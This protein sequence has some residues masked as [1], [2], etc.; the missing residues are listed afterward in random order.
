V[1]TLDGVPASS[2]PLWRAQSPYPL[3]GSAGGVASTNAL[4]RF[5]QA[6]SAFVA[7]WAVDG[8]T[9]VL[10]TNRNQPT[11]VPRVIGI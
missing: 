2:A 9:R 11:W 3:F 6:F 7:G 1:P 10:S 5:R 8:L 4:V